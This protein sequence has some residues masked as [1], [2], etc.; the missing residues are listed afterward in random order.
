MK[1]GYFASY[2]MWDPSEPTAQV[3]RDGWDQIK[4]VDIAFD[5]I[6][7]PEH[8]F[9]TIYLSPAPLLSV[10]DAARRMKR[11][12]LG[13]AVILSPYYH[14]LIMAE[15]IGLADQLTE[16]RLEVAFGRGMADLG[17]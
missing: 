16:G 7:F 17:S 12:R 13:A 9:T 10:V 3:Y 14:P 6:W 1:F 11:V 5:Y 8:H 4:L 2:P 15:Q